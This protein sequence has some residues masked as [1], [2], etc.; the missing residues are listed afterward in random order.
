MHA[1]IVVAHPDNHSLTHAIANGIADGLAS[2]E[3]RHSA[4]LADLAAEGFDP[5][6]NEADI[7]LFQKNAPAP[8]DVAAEHA[9]LERADALVLVETHEACS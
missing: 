7:A 3:A 9:R 1:L 4:E 5:R 2:M 6:F 8:A